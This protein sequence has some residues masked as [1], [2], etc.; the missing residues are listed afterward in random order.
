[1]TR[2]HVPNACFAHA[3]SSVL[4]CLCRFQ[5]PRCRFRKECGKTP[6]LRKSRHLYLSLDKL[7]PEVEDFYNRTSNVQP[8]SSNAHDITKGWF[9]VRANC[10]PTDCTS[11]AKSKTV[12]VC[13]AKKKR[14]RG[15]SDVLS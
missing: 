15:W 4:L 6:E 12:R 14:L 3:F 11:R 5:A 2:F 8:W 13:V 9:K 10:V 1:M 7:Q